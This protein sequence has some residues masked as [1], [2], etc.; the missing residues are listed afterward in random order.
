M[1]NTFNDKDRMQFLMFSYFNTTEL[2][3][4]P[5]SN[6]AY[7]DLCRTLRGLNGKGKDYRKYVNKEILTKDKIE[8]LFNANSQK[9]Y[10][11]KHKALCDKLVDYYKNQCYFSYGHAQ[12]WVNMTMKYLYVF[13]DESED[14]F[15]YM[16]MPLDSYIFKALD[17]EKIE[18]PKGSNKW[19]DLKWSQLKRDEY[20]ACQEKIQQ[21][22]PE[23]K[24]T[25]LS[26]EFEQ[27][28][29]IAQNKQSTKP[30]E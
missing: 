23:K 12:K 30:Q 6:R 29:M 28:L 21:Q 25:Q 4:E 10:N 2:K 11:E 8:P 27:W 18:C 22:I 26:W 14:K 9:D 16:H 13:G 24:H 17:N 1:G 19:S 3:V 7:R 15:K 20:I 5:A